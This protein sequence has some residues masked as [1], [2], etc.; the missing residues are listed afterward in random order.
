VDSTGAVTSGA[1]VTHR[2]ESQ[3]AHIVSSPL[4]R[5]RIPKIAQ[6]CLILA[7]LA[8]AAGISASPRRA[9]G[10]GQG[11]GIQ[12]PDD[13]G[14]SVDSNQQIFA[15]MCALDA[16]G[17]DADEN[18]LAEM[19]ARLA[20]REDLTKLHGP[21]TEAM[22]QFYRDHALASS[23]ETL[24]PFMTFALVSGPPPDF[25]LP[26]DPD[27]LPPS[28][29]TIEGFQERLAAFY[30]EANLAARWESVE[31]EAQPASVRFREILRKIVYVT[32]AYLREVEKPANGREF[33]VY[34]EPLVGARTNFRNTGVRYSIVVGGVSDSSVDLIQHAYLH[35]MLDRFVLRYRPLVETKRA[36]LN[37]AARAPQLPVEYHDDFVSLMDECLIKAV[38][39]RLRHLSPE[40]LEAALQDA[41]ASGFILVRPLVAQLRLFEKDAPAMSYYF[42]SLISGIDV[43]AEQKRVQGV[44]YAAADAAPART[45][46]GHAEEKPTSDLDRWITEGN[47]QIANRNAEAAAATFETAFAKYPNDP[48]VIYGL[49]ISS[50]LSGQGDRAKDLFEQLVAARNATPAGSA[51]APAPPD[52]TIIAWSHVYLGRIH[53]LEDERELAV[54]EYH[55]ALA[56]DGAPE[57]A[58]AAAQSGVEA[59]YQPRSR[60][61]ESRQPQP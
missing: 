43:A 46:H 60:P 59:A 26:P 36:L 48:R 57:A 12:S 27:Q 35:F 19:P 32:D 2:T 3:K 49:A 22:R 31:P 5:D 38:E 54:N 33:T 45:E 51:S 4:I 39:L 29:L 18:T 25:Q 28:V 16:S 42:P 9:Q 41:D 58:R 47:L 30:R 52:P 53:D 14:I 37:V 1:T 10:V 11:Q 23:A 20:L 61:D 50:V 44:K 34:V 24:S 40:N 17:F 15:T 8:A 13:R 7:L 6:A 21:A 56:V 55:A